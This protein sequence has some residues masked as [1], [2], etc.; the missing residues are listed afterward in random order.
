MLILNY[1]TKCKTYA[2][3][4]EKWAKRDKDDRQNVFAPTHAPN[5]AKALDM[6]RFPLHK[7]QASEHNGQHVLR[8]RKGKTPRLTTKIANN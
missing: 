1:Q 4:L 6:I 2:D 8:V 7:Q 5:D 3:C